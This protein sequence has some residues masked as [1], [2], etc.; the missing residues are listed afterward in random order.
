MKLYIDVLETVLFVAV[1]L[2][3]DPV[4]IASAWALLSL[5]KTCLAAWVAWRQHTGVPR[6]GKSG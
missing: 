4:L 6:L 1:L 3:P 5:V 2:G